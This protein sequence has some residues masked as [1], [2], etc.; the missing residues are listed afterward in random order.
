MLSQAADH[1]VVQRDA[2]QL[3]RI[4]TLLDSINVRKMFTATFYALVATI[5]HEHVLFDKLIALFFE[6]YLKFLMR[7]DFP[8]DPIL[9]L[10]PFIVSKAILLTF[11]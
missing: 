1:L 2:R 10:I 4:Y 5:Q 11:K 9:E 3:P 8:K 6:K 7:L